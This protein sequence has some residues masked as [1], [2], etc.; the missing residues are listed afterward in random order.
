MRGQI[1]FAMLTVALASC[2]DPARQP[3]SLQQFDA[4]RPQFATVTRTSRLVA[5]DMRSLDERIRR[6]NATGTR[7]AAIRLKVD[8]VQLSTRAG[9]VGNRVRALSVNDRR[10]APRRYFTLLTDALGRQ[11]LEGRRLERLADLVWTDPFIASPD[12]VRAVLRADAQAN[13]SARASVR[14][15][16]DAARLRR[17]HAAQFRYAVIRSGKG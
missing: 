6:G 1:L 2:G 14:D 4:L 5:Q 12:A 8:A 15:C 10:S 16:A 9:A 7:S 13:A 11:W 17:V 3:S